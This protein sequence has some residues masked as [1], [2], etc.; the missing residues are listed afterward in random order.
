MLPNTE[1]FFPHFFFYRTS[2]FWNFSIELNFL[3]LS[4]IIDVR[5]LNR[6]LGTPGAVC[7]GGTQGKT[8]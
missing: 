4:T 6:A 5:K 8:V 1:A 2:N 3:L 7:A